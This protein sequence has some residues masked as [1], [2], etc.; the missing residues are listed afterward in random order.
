MKSRVWVVTFDGDAFG[1][2]L[3]LEGSE[4]LVLADAD[5]VLLEVELLG[6]EAQ[7]AQPQLAHRLTVLLQLRHAPPL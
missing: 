6:V 4:A 3:L 1:G 7:Q 5:D 2:P